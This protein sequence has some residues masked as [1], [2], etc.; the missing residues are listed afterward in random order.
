MYLDLLQVDYKV[1][2]YRLKRIFLH[3]ELLSHS[4]TFVFAVASYGILSGINQ[5]LLLK[6]IFYLILSW[7]LRSYT[8]SL[9]GKVTI[10]Q[11]KTVFRK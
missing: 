7:A 6:L 8:S 9:R 4:H 10:L 11:K 3:R 1:N 2:I 5:T